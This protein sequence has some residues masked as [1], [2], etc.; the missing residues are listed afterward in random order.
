MHYEIDAL[1]TLY[2][3]LPVEILPEASEALRQYAELVNEF[4]TAH[5]DEL[6][7]NELAGTVSMGPVEPRSLTTIG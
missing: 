4:S 2:P 7:T 1:R 3:D 6:T 5:A